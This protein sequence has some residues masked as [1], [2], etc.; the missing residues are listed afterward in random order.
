MRRLRFLASR[1]ANRYLSPRPY[2]ATNDV[3]IGRNVRFGKNVVFSCKRI[4]IGDGVVFHDNITVDADV[5]EIG[6]YGTIY[7]HCFF[8][9]PGELFIGHNFWLG[10]SSIVDS[11]GGTYIGNNVGI[12]AQSQLWTHI[13][14]G[15]V[16]YGCRF[17]SDRP[18]QIGDDVWLV[19]H[20]LVS[21]VEIGER[22]M[23]MLGSVI[24]R[25]MQADHS[26]AG[27]PAE[28][29]TDKIGPQFEITGVE[30]RAAYLNSRLEEFATINRIS[31]IHNSIKIVSAAEEMLTYGADV[32]V[33]N[34]KDRTY[35]KRGTRLEHKLM[36]FLLPDAK[37]VPVS[38]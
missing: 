35:T 5:F 29:V 23:A 3:S 19:G 11:K 37:F 17:H 4:R 31:D 32:T 26:Y 13:V 20:C 1:A 28:D 24:T 38:D 36:R 9:G 21:P 15:D 10:I 25:D 16:M 27:V 18:L 30:H 12:G 34:V 22:S 8:P 7:S 14:Y 6:D 2:F 33:F